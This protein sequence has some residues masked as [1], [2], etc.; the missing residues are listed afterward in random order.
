MIPIYLV[1]DHEMYLEG[2]TLLLGKEKELTVTG[3]SRN[4][5]DFLQALPGL[6]GD[7]ILLLDIHLPDIE[8]EELLSQVRAQRPE[9]RI[10]YVTLMRGTRFIHRLLKYNVQG[11]LLK[12]APVEELL[13]AI[14]VVGGGGTYYSKEIDIQGKD[15]DA[16]HTV[17]IDNKK[18]DEILTRREQEVLRLI[19]KEFS[20]A[21]IAEKLFLSIGTVE[22]HRKRI[23]AKLGVN[24]TVGLVKFAVRHGLIDA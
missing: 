8:P 5:A 1:E 13:R 16:R 21:E 7:T 18:V 9:L 12:S 14:Q 19:C 10:I 11:Y 6:A 3:S 24:N 23:I 22:T 17:I 20:N 2:L 15:D 4:G